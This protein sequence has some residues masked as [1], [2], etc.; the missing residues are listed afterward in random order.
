[1]SE[2]L[3]TYLVVRLFGALSIGF[4]D[5]SQLRIPGGRQKALVALLASAP[6]MRRNRAWLIDKLWSDSDPVRGRANL[7]QL[8]H[9][10]K[11]TF[12]AEFQD[13]FEVATDTIG[14]RPGCV[15][16]RGNPEDGEL[17]EGFDLAQEGFEDWLRD[18][19]QSVAGR[20]ALFAQSV[21]Q[22][23]QT[24][25]PRIVV[26]PF[27]EIAQAARSGIG[28]A[29]AHEITS[30]FA[31]SQLIDAISH[32][33]ARAVADGH[34]APMSSADSL[35]ADYA[36]TGQCRQ[37]NDSLTVSVT[38][39]DLTAQRAIWSDT[40][41]IG[42]RGFLAGDD[43]LVGH[44][45]GQSLRLIMSRSV[46]ASVAIPLPR[47][48]AHSL[49]MSGVSLMHAFEYPYFRRAEAQLREVARRCRGHSEPLAWL[50]QWHLLRVFQKWSPDP[51]EDRRQARAAIAAALDLNPVCPLSLAI[52]GNI[53]TILYGD[54]ESAAR[55]FSA[56]QAINPSS[57][58]INHLASVLATFR[59]EGTEAVRLTER[60]Y[61]LSPRDPRQPFFQ[62]LSA[63]SYVVGGRYGQAVEMAEASLRRNPNHLS[64][65]RCRVI[66]LQLGGREVEARTAAA[67]LLLVDPGLTVS[68]YLRDHPAGQ[69][70]LGNRL[71]DA[72]KK[73]GIPAN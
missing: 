12:G 4:S 9:A 31:R 36:V 73:A 6:D 38:L 14:L 66:G 13:L 25:L 53:H 26:W 33:S 72:L 58:M 56:A 68:N 59:G 65:H 47:L 60:A 18:Q 35:K 50:A 17:L 5:G 44:V 64:A 55:R 63:G 2:R 27:G 46:A 30:G 61:A 3:G 49:M 37:I 39:Y 15:E 71:G 7:R 54:F 29:L 11:Q 42:F 70:D 69:S 28:D 43:T 51:E 67:E 16:L 41:K 1:M 52:D 57:A 34:G 20:A 24:V 40:H 22:P 32:F 62:T 23:T 10:V 19:R 21:P 45:V 8:L 48:Q